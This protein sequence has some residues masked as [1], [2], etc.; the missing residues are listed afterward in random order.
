MKKIYISIFC[1]TL[2]LS[3]SE[4]EIQSALSCS[5][6]TQ[7]TAAALTNFTDAT[8]GDYEAFCNAYKLTLQQ[9]KDA[10]GDSSGTIQT[11]I[12]GLGDCSVDDV[13]VEEN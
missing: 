10:C 3:C 9:Q 11:I 12:D 7:N 5:E 1:L 6:A 13:N 2:A 8:S 4:D